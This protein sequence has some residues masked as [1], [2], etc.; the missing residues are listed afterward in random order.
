VLA[1]LWGVRLG[2]HLVRRVAAEPEDGRYRYLRAHWHDDQRKF[3]AFFMAQALLTG[4]LSLPFFAAAQ[5]PD[6]S[7]WPWKI[8]AIAIWI[9]SVGGEA[10]ADRELAAFRA[11][12]AHRGT[13]CRVGLWRYSRHPNYFFE[14]THWFA[15][16]A[17][18][19]GAG[20]LVWLA[21]A[22]PVLMLVSLCWITGIPF[23]E[24]QALRSRGEEYRAYQR[25]TSAFVPWFPRRDP[26]SEARSS[27]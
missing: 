15:Y 2:V 3:F 1:G 18:S 16:V 17:L 22:G 10:I 19:I 9:V 5:N 24:A 20:S 12:D 25:T 27:T 23:V 26:S 8:A 13:T 21:A 14:W 4:L 6:A 11:D 7:F